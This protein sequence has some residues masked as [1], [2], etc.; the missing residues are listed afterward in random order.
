[1][2]FF[3]KILHPKDLV[4]KEY[5]DEQTD[6][7]EKKKVSKEEI[8]EYSAAEVETLWKEIFKS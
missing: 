1:M 4:T 5:V 3:G 6:N 2:K 8:S 7:L